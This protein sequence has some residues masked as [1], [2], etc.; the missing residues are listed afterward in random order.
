[1]CYSFIL[2]NS[3]RVLVLTKYVLMAFTPNSSSLT[4]NTLWSRSPLV[5]SCMNNGDERMQ[6]AYKTTSGAC[7]LECHRRQWCNSFLYTSQNSTC[8][9]CSLHYM[10][11]DV[12]DDDDVT[13][14]YRADSG[15]L[16]FLCVQ[17]FILFF[18]SIENNKYFHKGNQIYLFF[19]PLAPPPLFFFHREILS[20]GKW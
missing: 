12:S 8:R 10:D 1:M 15:E 4:S 5:T 17:R 19:L 20:A 6:T 7:A 9:L 2:T 16:A 18:I 14:Y 3:H 13:R 11:S